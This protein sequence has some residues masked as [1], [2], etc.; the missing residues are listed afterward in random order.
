MHPNPSRPNFDIPLAAL[1]FGAVAIASYSCWAFGSGVFRT[2]AA[3]YSACAVV[4]L[5]GGGPALHPSVRGVVSPPRFSVY[6]LLAFLAYAFFWCVGWFGIGSNTHGEIF[7]SMAGS[8]AFCRL[9]ILLCKRPVPALPC[10]AVFFL[11]HTAGYYMGEAAH[12]ALREMSPKLSMLAWGAL[13]GMGIGAGAG[14]LLGRIREAR[15]P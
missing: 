15:S 5:V 12:F 7:G 8:A 11:F 1:R 4:F 2:Q 13:H 6:F 10:I 9:L 3:L 14:Y